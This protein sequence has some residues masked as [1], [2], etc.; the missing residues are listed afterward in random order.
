M[1]WTA[2]T[3]TEDGR[4]LACVRYYIKDRTGPDIS[5][6]TALRLLQVWRNTNTKSKYHGEIM[7]Q[8]NRVIEWGHNR[9]MRLSRW[10]RA[11]S[12][13]RNFIESVDILWMKVDLPEQA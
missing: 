6:Q 7:A 11:R 13:D 8:E 10:V 1:H 2:E 4:Y 9:G 12:F 3:P 5:A